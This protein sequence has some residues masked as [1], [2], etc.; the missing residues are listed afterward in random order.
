[1]LVSIE[2]DIF[3]VYDLNRQEYQFDYEEVKAKII[4]KANNSSINEKITDGA[5]INIMFKKFNYYIDYD[6][7]IGCFE[8]SNYSKNL[9]KGSI[10][11]GLEEQICVKNNACIKC[12]KKDDDRNYDICFD[13]VSTNYGID[14]KRSYKAKRGNI[15]KWI[16]GVHIV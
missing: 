13:I 16:H 6:V 10:V 12:I 2:V 1:M 5:I 4:D 9:S 11:T 15:Y 3:R 7:V 8:R 14:K